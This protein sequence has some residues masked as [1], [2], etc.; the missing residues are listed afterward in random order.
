M[1]VYQH[2]SNHSE[3]NYRSHHDWKSGSPDQAWVRDCLA[4]G[5]DVC[6][7]KNVSEL[8]RQ[9]YFYICSY[10]GPS[11]Y[12][13]IQRMGEGGGLPNILHYYMAAC[14]QPCG[15]GNSFLRIKF[16]IVKLRE[17]HRSFRAGLMGLVGLV[18]VLHC[19]GWFLW[20]WWA[21]ESAWLVWFGLKS[22]QMKAWT[23][24]IQKE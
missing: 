5:E 12:Y 15:F 10:K 7:K 18:G 17:N 2:C 24:L 22:F 21:D 23:S 4:E 1:R 11:I 9:A 16:T 14:S 19:I 13:V 3:N 20:V 6:C 8:R